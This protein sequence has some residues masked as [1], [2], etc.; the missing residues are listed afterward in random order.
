MANL[1]G[2]AAGNGGHRQGDPTVLFDSSLLGVCG[3]VYQS[4]VRCWRTVVCLMAAAW[5]EWTSKGRCINDRRRPGTFARA[6]FPNTHLPTLRTLRKMD[7]V[8]FCTDSLRKKRKAVLAAI[9]SISDNDQS[10]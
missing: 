3:R 8:Q 10:H 6:F 1:Y 9:S 5:A 4:Y 2:H 7:C